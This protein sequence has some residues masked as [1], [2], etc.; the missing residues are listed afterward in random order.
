M[1]KDDPIESRPAGDAGELRC[2]EWECLVA[3]ALDGSLRG[4]QAAAFERHSRQCAACA[5]A[6]EQSRRGA[7]WLRFLEDEPAPPPGLVE[8]ILAATSGAQT[9]LPEE[10]PAVYE[11]ASSWRRSAPPA[12][13]PSV[14]PRLLMTAAMAF[15]SLAVT[16]NLLGVA[17]R[18]F[19]F[20][21]IHLS[22]LRPS[23]IG[24][25]VTRQYYSLE[26]RGAK[27]YDNLL[28][29]R[30]VETEARQLGASGE[31]QPSRNTT[32]PVGPLSPSSRKDG[33]GSGAPNS[34][35]V[36]LAFDRQVIPSGQA[37]GSRA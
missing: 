31:A 2:E 5:Q 36:V 11:P 16:I 34:R 32:L 10:L 8:A 14:A 18:R 17:P 15:F 25:T 28:L 9:A 33:A 19:S 3:E 35:A 22:G 37:H 1:A 24:S 23:A 13:R 7:E 12:S 6:L 4:A 26:E 20:T 30:E 27:F 21:A 29:V